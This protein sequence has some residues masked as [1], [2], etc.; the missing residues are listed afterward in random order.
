MPCHPESRAAIGF[1]ANTFQVNRTV[2]LLDHNLSPRLA[3]VSSRVSYR[4]SEASGFGSVS[5]TG[6]GQLS[7]FLNRT[8]Y[9]FFMSAIIS[10]KPLG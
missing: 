7:G 5:A 3:S 4:A 8:G 9:A 2:L 1:L 10:W 6:G